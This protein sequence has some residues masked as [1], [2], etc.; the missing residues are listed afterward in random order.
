[1]PDP[2]SKPCS[3]CGVEKP[4]TEYHSDRSRKSGLH[5]W[6]KQCARARRNAWYSKNREANRA[7]QAT[8]RDENR[9]AKQAYDRAWREANLDRKAAVDAAWREANKDRKAAVARARHQALRNDPDYRR[10]QQEAKRRRRAAKYNANGRPVVFDEI[11]QRDCGICGICGKPIMEITI[12]LDHILPLAAG[13]THDP[14]N[15]QVAHRTCNRRK[16]A[17]TNLVLAA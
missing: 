17:R 13:G 6:C 9:D 14:D 5:P 3:K 10:K 2:E 4:H 1:M 7:Y 12:E 16:G 11:L 8:W 15:V